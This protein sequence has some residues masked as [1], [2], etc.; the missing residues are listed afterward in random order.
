MALDEPQ[1]SDEVFDIDGFT[2]LIDKTFMEKAK[3]VKVDFIDY[4]FKLTSSIKFDGGC[5]GCGGSCE[6]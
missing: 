3:P 4:G 1:D 6:V 2:Y 5:G